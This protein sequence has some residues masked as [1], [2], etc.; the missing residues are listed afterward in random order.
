MATEAATTP[1]T[2]T[3]HVSESYSQFV[4]RQFRKNTL[5]VISGYIVAVLA[6]IAI[7][8]D[9]L[10]N[11]KPIVASYNGSVIFPVFREYGVDLGLTQWDKEFTS[12]DWKTVPFDWAVFPIVPYAPSTTD[13]NLLSLA[14]RAPSATHWLGTDDIGRDVLAGIIH[15]SRYA[16]SIGFVAM[17]IALVIGIVLGAVAGYFGGA[18]DIAISRLIEIFITFPRFFL[19]ITIVAMVEEGSLFLIMAIIGLTG[20]TNIAR[21]M[22]GEVL[23][24]RNLDYVSAAR[25]FGFSTPRIIARHVMP[26]AIAP[27]LIYAAFGIVGAILLESALSFLG[28][29]VPP[30]V[31]TWGSVLFKARSSASSWWLAIFPGLMI[32]LTVSAFN[33]IGDAL[34][35]ATDPR[36][37]T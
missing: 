8:A 30:T 31:V 10:A 35:D 34:R 23:R 36:L 16:L 26:N 2:Q 1:G 17:G 3:A 18:V 15:G 37:R 7:F 25:A 13:K 20:W 11:D 24:V 9:V 4:R 5:G 28:F 22:R 14:Q 6:G 32:F 33:L 29:G 21:F 27:V 12:V 19:I